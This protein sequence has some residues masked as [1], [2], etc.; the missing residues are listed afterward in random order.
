MLQKTDFLEAVRQTCEKDPRYRPEAYVF[1]KQA[2][3]FTME[4]LNKPREGEG[5]DVSCAELLDGTRQF[6]LREFGP[7]AQ[8]VLKSWGIN[9]T[10]DFGEIVFNIIDTGHF[11]K[12][13]EDKKENFANGYDFHEAFEQPFLPTGK[14]KRP[15]KTTGSSKA[16]PKR[17][18]PKKRE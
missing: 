9:R 14:G 8:T 18:K 2:F 1:V 10:E 17:P 6:A 12:T 3:D 5:R 16:S 7:L 13:S 15:T 4:M 11:G